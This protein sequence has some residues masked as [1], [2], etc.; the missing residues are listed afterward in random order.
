[1]RFI[2]ESEQALHDFQKPLI[3]IFAKNNIG[4]DLSMIPYPYLWQ[5]YSDCPPLLTHAGT[6]LLQAASSFMPL[7]AAFSPLHFYL[8]PSNPKNC[9][10]LFISFI[11]NS[12]KNI[13]DDPPLANGATASERKALTICQPPSAKVALGPER[14]AHRQEKNG[15][16]PARNAPCQSLN[17][18]HRVNF[19]LPMHIL[20]KAFGIS[21]GF[22]STPG[23]LN[24]GKE[25]THP[26]ENAPVML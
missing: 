6:T 19:R 8:S 18:R 24:T 10:F 20:S 16:K 23:L 7:I 11:A 26:P 4:V 14:E 5:D 22:A 13:V 21:L 9:F 15:L 1:M 2:E 12:K 17:H 3:T 25:L